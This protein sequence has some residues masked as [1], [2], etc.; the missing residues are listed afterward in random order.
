MTPRHE[1]SHAIAANCN[2]ARG[3]APTRFERAT[4]PLGGGCSIQL[5]YGAG[6]GGSFARNRP[7]CDLSSVVRR[8]ASGQITG[9]SEWRG[10]AQ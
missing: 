1:G 10:D 4:F 2:K 8:M 7:G 5:S 9:P 6:G 3:A